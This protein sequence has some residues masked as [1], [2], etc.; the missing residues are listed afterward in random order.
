MKGFGLACVGGIL[1][2]VQADSYTMEAKQ[3]RGSSNFNPIEIDTK[4]RMSNENNSLFW[5]DLKTAL[6][7]PTLEQINLQRNISQY[8]KTLKNKARQSQNF[9]SVSKRLGVN[10][11]IQ[12]TNYSDLIYYGSLYLGSENEEMNVMFDT[13][14]DWLLIQGENCLTCPDGQ[15][16]QY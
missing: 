10:D 3:L 5:M 16:Y 8:K 7:T 12:I 14:Y 1:S 11:Q 15:R 13:S 9:G 4:F 6:E 2:G